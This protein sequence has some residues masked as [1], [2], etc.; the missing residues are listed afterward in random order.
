MR[1]LV[2]TS[3]LVRLQRNQAAAAWDDVVERGL[4][5]V[6]E[7]VLAEAMSIADAKGY[8]AI[9]ERILALYPWAA[10]PDDIWSLVS[11]IRHEL[12]LPS[13]YQGVSV[14]DLVVAATAI[15]LK[16]VVLHEDGDFETIARHVPELRQQRVSV[17]P[18]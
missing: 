15:R 4:I 16:L 11:A 6:C 17:E 12:I 13:V 3:A 5:V 1:F 18:G 7:P 10:I 2:D 9:E 8:E 14:A